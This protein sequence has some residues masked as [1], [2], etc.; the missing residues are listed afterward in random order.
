MSQGAASEI[1]GP[2]RLTIIQMGDYAEAFQRFDAGEEETYYAQKFTVDFLGELL[3]IGAAQAVTVVTA[4]RDAPRR[5]MA[6]GVETVGV[7]LFRQGQRPRY[8]EMI[9]LLNQIASTHVIIALP[10]AQLLRWAL[11][12]KVQ[13]LPLFADSFRSTRLR[14][15]VR[16]FRLARLLNNQ[17]VPFIANHNIAASLD[18]QRIGVKQHKIIPFDWPALVSPRDYAPKPAPKPG[19]LQIV[20]VG[21]ITEI[22]GVGDAIEALARL[23][24]DG[25][26][27]N[28]SLIGKGET[29]R[30]QALAKAKGV[31]S[32]VRFLG[33][34]SH[35]K[36]LEA[37]REGDV[38]LVPSHHDYPEGLPMT[39]YEAMSVRT[40]LVTSDHPMFGL[41][42]RDGEN[43]LVFPAGDPE[44][45]TAVIR[46]LVEEPELYGH[47]S[48]QQ[49]RA[50]DGYLCPLKWQDLVSGFLDKAQWPRLCSYS[51]ADYDYGV[52]D[53]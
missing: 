46:R 35:R 15:R 44:A 27:A 22:K 9:A 7:E 48:Q 18:L 1:N 41:R 39:L 14:D 20:Y 11:G 38:V 17:S 51:L 12:R 21:Q 4:S 3:S 8:R 45:L 29:D 47:I 40:P 32:Q 37:M 2:P 19:P 31:A 36:V 34:L 23:N 30:F 10:Q 43:A 24:K 52:A 25:P 13:V 49:G 28:L 5:T 50:A 26:F 6:N 53:K 33:Q 16:Y 42:I